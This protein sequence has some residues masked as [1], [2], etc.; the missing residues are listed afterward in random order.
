M[1]F[2]GARLIPGSQVSQW[3]T[4]ADKKIDIPTR[5]GPGDGWAQYVDD[6]LTSLS[7]LAPG[8]AGT[9]SVDT[10]VKAAADANSQMRALC[11]TSAPTSPCAQLIECEIE[12]P[13]D[14]ASAND[15]A[16]LGWLTSDASGRWVGL[17]RGNDQVAFLQDAVQW[18]STASYGH[19]AAGTWVR[20]RVLWDHGANS[21]SIWANGVLQITAAISQSFT[22][23]MKPSILYH[24]DSS[25]TSCR[26]RNL[27]AWYQVN[28]TYTQL[29]A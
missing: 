9:W 24:N 11:N 28:A 3:V 26:F 15:H 27:K 2:P 10:Y 6:P 13:S 12:V 20:L 4:N 7:T 14:F 21:W 8:S 19:G 1:S 18:G 5:G 29:P 23:G 17:L 25:G 16:S 22:T